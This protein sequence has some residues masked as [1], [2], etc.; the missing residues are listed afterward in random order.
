MIS[1]PSSAIEPP[2]AAAKTRQ[3]LDQFD[4]SVPIDACDAE[5]FA[6]SHLKREWAEAWTPQIVDREPDLAF[7]HGTVSGRRDD[8]PPDHHFRE[9]LSGH[10][11]DR[12]A[13]RHST[14]A[15]HDD[16]IADLEN[17]RKL[18]ADEH[19][20]L[21]FRAQ[22]AKDRNEFG[23]LTRR[24]IGSRLVEDQQFRFAQERFED[25]DA[26]ATTERQISDDR[27]GIEIEP[28]PPAR[29][30]YA[31]CDLGSLKNPSCLRPTEHHVFEDR[32]RLDQHEVLMDHGDARRHRLGGAMK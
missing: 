26:L 19:D 32:H 2:F 16:A 29:L 15:Q 4:L 10:R 14:R 6:S 28:K 1:R 7:G 20:A 17:L 30:A 5:N 24:Q 27:V 9:L 21:S 25:F 12:R 13:S 23:D 18:V 8:V 31:R 3:R 22:P 11:A